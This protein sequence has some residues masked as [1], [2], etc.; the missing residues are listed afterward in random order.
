MQRTW[1]RVGAELAGKRLEDSARSIDKPAVLRAIQSIEWREIPKEGR[2]EAP[3][4]QGEGIKSAI[5]SLRIPKVSHVA[6]SNELAPY[7]FYGIRGHYKDGQAE[8]YI[9]HT[10]CELVP[11]CSDFEP[12]SQTQRSNASE[13]N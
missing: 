13:T 7:G 4:M 10:G 3:M 1:T 9:V 6:W 11:M 2:M 12:S 8:V 5:Q